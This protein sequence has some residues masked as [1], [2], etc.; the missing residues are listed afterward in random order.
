MHCNDTSKISFSGLS[1]DPLHLPPLFYELLS[2]LAASGCVGGDLSGLCYVRAVCYFP[3]TKLN[4]CEDYKC[5]I[6]EEALVCLKTIHL[7]SK[8]QNIIPLNN[9]S[10]QCSPIAMFY[11]GKAEAFLPRWG[12]V[13]SYPVSLAVLQCRAD[14]ATLDADSSLLSSAV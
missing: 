4:S 8:R 9:S 2:E 11:R 10:I 12:Q 14:M 13:A 5:I 1:L 3:A 7:K 6:W